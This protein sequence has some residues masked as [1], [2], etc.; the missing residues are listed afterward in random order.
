MPW[1]KKKDCIGFGICVEECPADAISLIDEKAEINM[2]DCIRCGICHEVCPQNAARH[3]SEKIP[4][5]VEDNIEWT[6]ELL[7]NYQTKKERKAFIKRM[8]KH[9]LKEREV[10]GRTLK[11]IKSIKI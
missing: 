4:Q 2:E 6:R 7:K 10:I 5:K 9:F 1:I 11:K 8:E 3:D